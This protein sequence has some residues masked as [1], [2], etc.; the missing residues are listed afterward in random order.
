MFLNVCKQ[1]FH[2]SHVRISHKLKGVLI[3][4]LQPIIFI[5]ANSVNTKIPPFQPNSYSFLQ[6]H[7]QL[8]ERRCDNVV[9]TLL[10]T[11]SQCCDTVENEVVPTSVSDVV[12][13]SLSDVIKTLPQRCCNVATTFSILVQTIL[14][15]FPSSKRETVTKVLSGI[16]HTSSLF[17]RTLYL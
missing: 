12:T 17:K 5:L 13:T 11:L 7:T 1:S 3:W 4:N 16:K 8:A 15:S 9:T 2:T 6:D 14:I 10:L